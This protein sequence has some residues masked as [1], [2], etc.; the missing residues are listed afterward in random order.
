M[1]N[2]YKIAIAG[3]HAGFALKAELSAYLTSL[4]H[5]VED[6]GPFNSDSVDYPDYAHPLADAVASGRAERGVV[7]CGS[8]IGVSI[9]VNRHKGVRG[10]LV[11]NA[12][13]ASL[14]RQHNNANVICLAARFT[15]AADAREFVR[16]FLE[17][18]YEGGRHERRVEKIG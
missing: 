4:G 6:L 16:I 7:I 17:T 12:E 5:Q 2:P 8:G 1:Q 15:P 14:C 10:A 3:D 9:V 13:V 11:W 18:A